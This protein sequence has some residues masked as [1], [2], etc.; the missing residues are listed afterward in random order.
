MPNGSAEN[1]VAALR[2]LLG[3]DIV[4]ITGAA[5]FLTE[6]AQAL[7]TFRKGGANNRRTASCAYLEALAKLSDNVLT[8]LGVPATGQWQL[9]EPLQYVHGAFSD[10]ERP[11]APELSRRLER[12]YDQIRRIRWHAIAAIGMEFLV[13]QGKSELCAAKIAGKQF[14]VEANAVNNLR[15]EAKRRKG[16]RK[17]EALQTTYRRLENYLYFPDDPARA[18]DALIELAAQESGNKV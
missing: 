2:D 8:G 1:L 5:G 11:V 14:G 7:V 16:S 18:Y 9:C 13:R 6:L 12:N 15:D 3:S 17:Y 4:V 10:F